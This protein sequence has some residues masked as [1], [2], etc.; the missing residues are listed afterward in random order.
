M[1]TVIHHICKQEKHEKHENL[2]PPG[3]GPEKHETPENTKNKHMNTV[4]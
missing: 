1:K 4:I 2:N 3:L